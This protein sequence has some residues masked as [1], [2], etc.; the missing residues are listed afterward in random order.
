MAMSAMTNRRRILTLLKLSNRASTIK[1][2][3]KT[4]NDTTP[5]VTPSPHAPGSL[6]IGHLPF[7]YE[8]S[9]AIDAKTIIENNFF[10]RRN[11]NK[12]HI[13]LTSKLERENVFFFL[14][15][16]TIPSIRSM[17]WGFLIN[18]TGSNGPPAIPDP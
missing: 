17:T 18:A 13:N 5:K 14:F 15:L 7:A 2:T 8:S 12:M 9:E 4:K 10:Y 16:L 3:S 6:S 11:Q 1:K